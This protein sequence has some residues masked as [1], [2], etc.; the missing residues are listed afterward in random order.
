MRVLH[1]ADVHLDRPFIGMELEAAR[2]RRARLRQAFDR[3]LGLARKCDVD[4]ITI[5]GDLWEDE[6]VT[7]DTVRWVAERLTRVGLPVVIVAGNH[8]ALSPGGPFDRAPWGDDVTVMP[9]E[10][11]LTPTDVGEMTIWG[12]S[13]RRSHPLTSSALKNFRV[14]DDGRRHVLLLHGTGGAYSDEAPHCP[15]TGDD[16]RRAG[17]DLCLAGHLHGGGVRDSIVVYPGSPEPLTWSEDGRHTAAI[18]DL[19]ITGDPV[20]D[21]V[22][23]NSA[24][25]AV[26]QVDV[27]GADSSADV[28]RQ[29]LAALAALGPL[30]DLHLRLELEGRVAAGCDSSAAAIVNTL[31]RRGLASIAVHDRTRPAFDLDALAAGTGARAMF[32]KRMRERI[33]NGD[34]VAEVALHLGLR[35]LAGETL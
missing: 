3:C 27:T 1:L 34:E 25:Y 32:V 21:L 31:E 9:A 22:D 6:H 11:A 26:R 28:E 20:I 24:R 13:W 12:M 10:A 35:A 19:P 29:A 5:G 8:D 18:V 30:G 15:F 16:V 17:F 2:E 14:P 23:V 33:E 7:P 4:A